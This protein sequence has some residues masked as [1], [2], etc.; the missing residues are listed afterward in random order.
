MKRQGKEEAQL[1]GEGKSKCVVIKCWRGDE[2][3]QGSN[4]KGASA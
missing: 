1:S 3:C 2:E 4:E